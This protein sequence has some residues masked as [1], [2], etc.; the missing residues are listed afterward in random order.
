MPDF[1]CVVYFTGS[2]G[3]GSDSRR[4][5]RHLRGCDTALGGTR[6]VSVRASVVFK[7]CINRCEMTINSPFIRPTV[8]DV[9]GPFDMLLA[10]KKQRGAECDDDSTSNSLFLLCHMPANSHLNS[11]MFVTIQERQVGV[12]NYLFK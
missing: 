7:S 4:Y 3:D 6:R 9:S 8:G 1:L 10:K 5:I 2:V 11:I 12:S